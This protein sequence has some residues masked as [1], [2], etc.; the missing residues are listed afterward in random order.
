MGNFGGHTLP[1]SFFII[2][3]LWYFVRLFQLYYSSR[4]RNAR[5]TSRIMM[6]CPCLCGRFKDLP[7]EAFVKIFLISIGFGLEI[8]TGMS[9]GKFVAVGNGQHATMFFFF[10]LTGVVDI[11]Q[12]YR[13]PMP[14]DTDYISYVIALTIEGILFKFHLHG[15]TEL[16]V[17]VHT[18]LLYVIFIGVISVLV[19]MRYRHN[20]LAPLART[21]FLLLQGT[22]FWQIAFILFN[23]IEGASP[24]KQD[25]HQHM[26]IA[27]LYFT[28]HCGVNF[29]LVLLIGAVIACCYGRGNGGHREE[30]EMSMKRLIH[31]GANGQTL[32]SL[33]DESDSDVEFQKPVT[34]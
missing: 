15:R 22:W 34:K 8:Y 17:L 31:T 12:Y 6:T 18:F 26:M 5:F 9:H 21:Y 16:D 2:F 7:V 4:Q 11:L 29:V 33:N 25:D 10:G 1:G 32:V 19:E 24:W 23:P 27:T 20:I 14:P 3:A 30:D 28:W 13:A